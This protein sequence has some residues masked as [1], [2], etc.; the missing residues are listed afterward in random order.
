MLTHK[1][2]GAALTAPATVMLAEEKE[3]FAA[4]AVLGQPEIVRV[5]VEDPEGA[6]TFVGHKTWEMVED[7]CATGDQTV[8]RG[9]VGR[10]RISRSATGTVAYPV[11]TGRRWEI[12]LI[13]ANTFLVRRILRASATTTGRPAETVSQR[14]TWLLTTVGFSGL[15][16]DH[17][18][19]E[20]S[21]VSMDATD[22]Q[23]RTGQDVLQDCALASGYNYFIRYR[24]ASTDYELVFQAPTSAAD[25]SILRISNVEADFDFAT[26]WPASFT[27]YL[28]QS[29]ERVAA[30]V[31]L[32]YS[33]G[34]VYSFGTAVGTAFAPVDL[35]APTANVTSATTA[36]ALLTRL[37]AQ[38]DDEEETVHDQIR[39]PAD[40]LNDV[41]HGQII[42]AKYSHLPGWTDFR[43]AR[44]NLKSFK[45]PPN[46]TQDEY[47][48]AL[49]LK[50]VTVLDYTATDARITR[51]NSSESPGG[52]AAQAWR[53]DFDQDG[54][55]PRSG[56]TAFPLVGLA[57]YQGPANER[58]GITVLGSGT[59]TAVLACSVGE[60]VTGSHT[61]TF[62]IRKNG[63]T[64]ASSA[65]TTSGGLRN[66]QYEIIAGTS[67]V[68]SFAVVTN[69]VIS[70]YID[71]TE[72]VSGSHV[73]LPTGVGNADHWLR[74]YGNLA[75]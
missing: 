50:P 4:R 51:P 47:D 19:V 34:S 68:A 41:K 22:Y 36:S 54:D 30:G 59:I 55:D 7:E 57:T 9:F 18:L 31:A 1:Y 48:V 25:E 69:D 56:D 15:I 40:H 3:G 72:G 71:A 8:W 61:F 21:S 46:L 58:T 17:G 66:Q 23:D 14:I 29:P 2:N 26:T 33:G 12:E 42:S 11:S 20:A 24:E 13:E 27:A 73:T 37:L 16:V 63:V 39:V 74:I 60:V 45:R 10:K 65:S 53:I 62:Q 32:P 67:L 6:L 38:H 64:V 44:V 52:H 49:E 28:E 35:V 75:A 5:V 43:S 70:A